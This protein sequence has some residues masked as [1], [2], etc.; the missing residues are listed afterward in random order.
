VVATRAGVCFERTIDGTLSG[1]DVVGV[2]MPIG[3]PRDGRRAADADARRLLGRRASTIFPT[4]PRAALPHLTHEAASAAARAA[5]GK[6]LSIQSFHLLAKVRELDALVQP[7]GDD[8]LLEVHP[9]CSFVLMAGGAPLPSKHT[10]EGL[11]T[12]AALLLPEFGPVAPLRGARFDDVLDAYA[13]L[14]SAERFA[15]GEHVSFGD[16]AR[17]E[18]GILMRIVA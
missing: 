14:W 5:T 2:D 12:R 3:L 10:A 15:R 13:V 11:T 18:R 17:D 9:E 7:D 8:R 4:P 16:G 6:G 1:Y